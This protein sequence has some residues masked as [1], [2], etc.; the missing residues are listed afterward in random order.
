MNTV[1]NKNGEL[2]GHNTD[3]LGAVNALK[4]KTGLKGKRI[5]L[6]GAGGAAKAIAFALKNEGAR[7]TIAGRKKSKSKKAQKLAKSI[8]GKNIC[9]EE[10][11]SLEGFDILI[12]ATPVGMKPNQK[13]SPVPAK[14]LHKKLVVF[15]IVYS[16]LKTELLKEAKKKKCKTIG[17]IEMLLEQGYLGFELFTGKKAP[18]E[19]MRKAIIKE[20]N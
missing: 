9:I 20:L 7:I 12:N 3:G 6:L 13:K 4:K 1:V 10:I 15:D 5:L 19:K 18:K 8:N 16:P 11:V 14:L 17:G 2:I